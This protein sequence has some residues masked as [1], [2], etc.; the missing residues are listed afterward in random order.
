MLYSRSIHAQKAEFNSSIGADA[1]ELRL[2]LELVLDDLV[3]S[4][5]L[6]LAV[7]LIGLVAHPLDVQFDQDSEQMARDVDLAVVDIDAR[8][9]TVA[10]QAVA[11]AV[12]QGGQLLVEVVLAEQDLAGEVVEPQEQVGFLAATGSV[13]PD[14]VAGVGLHQSQGVGRLEGAKG[15]AR[16]VG[17]QAVAGALGE[18]VVGQEAVHGAI[19]D[20][21]DLGAEFG[22]GGDQL[23]QL[24]DASGGQFVDQLQQLGTQ[25]RI[26]DPR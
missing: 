3:G 16:I 14:A 1:G 15:G 23:A 17:E 12:E 22:V 19:R 8:R 10:Q 26:V 21:R 25:C 24:R 4:L 20:A 7:G 11:E 13:E 2:T 18:A 5:D 9:D 6:A